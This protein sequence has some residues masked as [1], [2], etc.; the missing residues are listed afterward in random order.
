MAVFLTVYYDL[1]IIRYFFENVIQGCS[2]LFYFS[3]PRVTSNGIKIKAG[4]MRG[5]ER[6]C[7]G[8]VCVCVL[9]VGGGLR[10]KN[11]FTCQ[12]VALDLTCATRPERVPEVRLERGEGG[13]REGAC[14]LK[15]GHGSAPVSGILNSRD[16]KR[17]GER[18]EEEDEERGLLFKSAAVRRA[19][20]GGKGE[21]GGKSVNQRLM[22]FTFLSLFVCFAG[23]KGSEERGERMKRWGGGDERI[24]VGY[25][26]LLILFISKIV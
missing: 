6:L 14:V 5:R 20:R 10:K 12:I 3:P 18:E 19:A 16:R 2:H 23:E 4:E 26:L 11:S 17:R 13:G 9:G 25:T 22:R 24:K 21:G 8:S 7:V 15:T 1:L